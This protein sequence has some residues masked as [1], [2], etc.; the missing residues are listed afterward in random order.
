MRW[1]NWLCYKD[2]GA[3]F[4]AETWLTG[5]DSDQRIIDDSF[6]H[7]HALLTQQN[8]FH[9]ER[10]LFEFPLSLCRHSYQ[11][12]FLWASVS[13]RGSLFSP[14]KPLMI[15]L[16]IINASLLAPIPQWR[17]TISVHAQ[18]PTHRNYLQAC[19]YTEND[20]NW[21][22]FS[23]MESQRHTDSEDM[24]NLSGLEWVCIF[25]LRCSTLQG[26]ISGVSGH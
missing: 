24:A 17:W 12:L 1:H 7:R 13:H 21:W 20:N 9:L 4:I 8:D 3:L 16:L 14:T 22:T 15:L 6:T 11:I 5:K 19:S 25:T 23:A 10:K 26:F 2:L 18:C